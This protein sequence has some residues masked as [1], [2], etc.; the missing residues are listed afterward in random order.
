MLRRIIRPARRLPL[1][2]ILT[3]VGPFIFEVVVHQWQYSVPRPASELDA[4]FFTSCQEPDVSAKR[5]NAALVM[6]ARN[7]ELEKA[8]RTVTS[9]E[10]QFN[11]WFNYPYVFLNDEKW[12]PNFIEVLNK[13]AR[14]LATFDVIPQTQWTFPEGVDIDAAKQN[15]KE[16]GERGIP[17][18]GEEGY[19]HM[20]RFYSGK[21]Y[22]LDVLKKYK[23]YW[24]LEPD[25]DFTCAITYDPFVQMAR[26]KK[27]YGFTIALWEV[28]KSCPGL[29][30][31]IA[32]WKEMMGIPTSSLWKA[33]VSA[34]WMPYPFRRFMSWLPNRDAYGDGWSLC[35]YWS[36]FE[37]ADMDFFRT[38]AYQDLFDYLDKKGG[39]YFE[40]WGD[41]AVHSLAIAMLADPR[42]V[43]HFEDFGYRHAL[44][45]Q[46]PANAPGGQLP[47]SQLL[48]SGTWAAEEDNGIGCR[49]ECPGPSPRNY[50][51]YCLNKLKQPTTIKRPWFASFL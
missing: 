10:Q 14:G 19:H 32:D 5:E 27:V 22:Q 9:I 37:I 7:N 3:V 17:H 50:G 4:P 47:E 46:C 49:C 44:L 36:N 51:S 20:C 39:F 1:W 21:F 43:H 38:R 13:T 18:A 24:R 31:S 25:V 33:T 15:I 30:R 6:L 12:D 29:Y 45:Y 8:N 28:G 40:R 23:W 2:L 34:S 35:H 41:A 16:Q 11:R 48:G 26:H 42:K